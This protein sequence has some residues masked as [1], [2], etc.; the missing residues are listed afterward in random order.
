MNIS[1]LERVASARGRKVTESS[2]EDE[3]ANE[4]KEKTLDHAR[5]V[6]TKKKQRS[7]GTTASRAPGD[8]VRGHLLP[9]GVIFA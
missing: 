2:W 6:P 1:S 3:T 9:A 4:M 7:S 8:E 5:C